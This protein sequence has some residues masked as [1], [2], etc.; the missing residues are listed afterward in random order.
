M[1]DRML[2][3]ML[4]DFV[5]TGALGVVYPDGRE[6]TYGEADAPRVSLRLHDPGLVR[7][8][9]LRTEL[10]LGEA[11]MDGT[12]TLDGDDLEG[13]LSLATRNAALSDGLWWRRLTRAV[14][15]VRRTIDQYNPAP[16]ARANV[17]HHYDLSG[18][19]YD[20]FLDADRQYSCAY[21]TD[22]NMTLEAAQEAKKHHIAG[23]LL[24]RPGMEVFEIGCGWGGMALTL[25]RDYGVKV[26]GVTLSEEQHKIATERAA[27]AGLSDRVRFLLKDYRAVDGA[28][29]PRRLHRHVRACG[30][31][32]L[33]GV[34][35]HGEGTA[36][37]RRRGA[38]PHDR[39]RR[40]ARGHLALDREIHLPRRL[41]PCHVRGRPRRGGRR[42]VPLRPRGL[43][44][45][46]RR[47]AAPLVR[48]VRSAGGGGARAL[49]RAV[50][51]DVAL[52]PEGL[53]SHVPP[54]PAMRVPVAARPP[55]RRPCR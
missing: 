37:A 18:A 36:E 8:L 32:P 26:L 39:A 47:D 44:P 45:A 15:R 28:V 43:A 3:R 7:R 21:F 33:Q 52:L 22:P 55:A 23:K 50:L 14:R 4:R 49:R 24:L 54:Q 46:L 16:R 6:R 51:P 27:A 30:R 31:A 13:L 10:T 41:C 35:R 5:R 53:G 29:R 2:D 25:A 1:W 38:D 19:L 48:P 9:V 11:Y 17:A 42:P 40:T 20:L 12:L 34:F